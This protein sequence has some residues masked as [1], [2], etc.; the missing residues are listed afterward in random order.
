MRAGGN[1][2]SRVARI[3]DEPS[4]RATSVR[5]A[6]CDCSLRNRFGHR[7]GCVAGYRHGLPLAGLRGV[8]WRCLRCPQRR[9]MISLVA[10]ILWLG[11]SIAFAQGSAGRVSGRVTD[12]TGGRLPGV[13][14]VLALDGGPQRTAATDGS[15]GFAFDA[16]SP[17]NYNVTFSLIN[18]AQQTKRGVRVAAGQSV[19]LDTI[20]AADVD[21]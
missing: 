2:F 5:R 16:V 17:G 13:V 3:I 12:V 21:G 9:G 1:L 20:L 18:F 4:D 8:L 11:S 19:S 7:H 15:G 6:C 10:G 14:V